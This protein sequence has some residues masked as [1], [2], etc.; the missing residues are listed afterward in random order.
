MS[1]NSLSEVFNVR[2]GN[3]IYDINSYTTVSNSEI[4]PENLYDDTG[5]R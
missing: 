1:D 2:G 3:N 4:N 5:Q